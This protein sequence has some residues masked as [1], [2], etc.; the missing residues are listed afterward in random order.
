M[1]KIIFL[2]F[3]LLTLFPAFA[4]EPDDISVDTTEV[5]AETVPDSL[6]VT[7][8]GSVICFPTGEAVESA[9]IIKQLVDDNKGNWPTTVWGFVM[10]VG[11]F[12]LS[13]PGA[14]LLVNMNK[15]YQSL[16]VI[17]RDTLA[18]VAA[19]AGALATGV[20]FLVGLITGSGFTWDIFMVVWGP[21][22]FGSVVFY[23]RVLKKKEPQ[24]DVPVA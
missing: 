19:V 22:A 23:E 15:V 18:I 21:I 11:G 4:Q 17:F 3:F 6:C 2:S 20:S 1:K 5:A 13:A 7:L 10:L 24:A 8:D 16:K 14:A 12:L 9:A